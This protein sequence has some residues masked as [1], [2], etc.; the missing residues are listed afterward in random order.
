MPVLGR[1]GS[2]TWPWVSV[3]AAGFWA[4]ASVRATDAAPQKGIPVWGDFWLDLWA[5]FAIGS[6]SFAGP[7][8]N[9]PRLHPASPVHSKYDL[10]GCQQYCTYL[11]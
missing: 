6:S 5:S 9:E 8:A 7:A 10:R 1:A 2:S 3:A 4:W 11:P